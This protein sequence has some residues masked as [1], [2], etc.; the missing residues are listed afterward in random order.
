MKLLDTYAAVMMAVLMLH[1]LGLFILAM[2][3]AIVTLSLLVVIMTVQVCR[4]LWPRSRNA[5]RI[6]AW[7]RL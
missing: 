4:C 5:A 7:V 2:A 1:L 3:S 6:L